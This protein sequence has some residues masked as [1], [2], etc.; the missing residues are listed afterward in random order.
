MSA[1]VVANSCRLTIIS[2]T[3]RVDLSVP[4]QISVAELLTIVVSSLGRDAADRGAS[5]GGWVLQRAAEAPLD[6]SSSLAA[7][8]LRDG[9][10]LHL[11][12]RSTH[13]PEVA[14]DDVLDAV[15]TGV[16]SRT[17]RWVGDHTMRATSTFAGVLLVFTLG[18]LLLVGPNWQPSTIA[19]GVIA[20]LLILT[21]AAVARVYHRRVP[22]LVAGSFAVAFA[23]AAGLTGLGGHHQL[24]DFGA[25]QVLVG[26]CAAALAATVLLAVIGSGFSGLVAVVTVS[27]LTAVATTVAT[28][29][30]LSG[31]ATASITATVALALSP[32]LPT[33]SFRLSRLP[34]PTIVQ[35]A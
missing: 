5:E 9:D 6:P 4:S 11:R 33:L 24:V 35:D 21:A 3:L 2:S 1:S 27:L 20:V 29:S 31:P 25:P 13:L 28:A 18:V 22:A 26:V 8:Q 34:L 23:S 30:T 7:N 10:V 16:L 32:F 19:S 14:F 12:T 15:A 17:S